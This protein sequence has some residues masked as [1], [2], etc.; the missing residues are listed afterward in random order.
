MSMQNKLFT[1]AQ[2]IIDWSKNSEQLGLFECLITAAHETFKDN[3]KIIFLGN[4]GSAAEASHLAGEFVGKCSKPSRAL[5]ALSLSDSSVLMTALSNDYGVEQMFVRG[6]EAHAGAHDLIIMLS[7]SGTSANI[8]AALEF[9]KIKKL[10]TSLWTSERFPGN[11]EVSNFTII[12]PTKS[13]PRAQ[14]LHL[15]LGHILA[16]QIEMSYLE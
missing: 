6:L 9:T 5:S 3:G 13:T 12:A 7:T 16:E 4:G 8:R 14:E 1:S 11:P 15:V 10:K 2:T